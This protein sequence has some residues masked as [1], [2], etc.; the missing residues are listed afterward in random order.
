MGNANLK[1]TKR[2]IN[3]NNNILSASD[4]KHFFLRAETLR[5]VQ[6]L[7]ASPIPLAL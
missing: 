5:N 2:A 7:A 6:M 1:V 3:A 4:A